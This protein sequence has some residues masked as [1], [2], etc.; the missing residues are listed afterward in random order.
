MNGIVH[1]GSKDRLLGYVRSHSHDPSLRIKQPIRMR[2]LPGRS[3]EYLSSLH[4]L[5]SLTLR[6]IIIEHI[7][8]EGFHT[9]FS[10]FRETLTY[11]SLDAFTA[12][13]FSALVTLVDYFPNITTLEL[14]P[15]KL[16]PDEGPA[17]SLSRPFR[18]KLHVHECP[19]N[20][21]GFFNLFARLDLEYEELAISSN[22]VMGSMF[23][24]SVLEISTSTIKFLKLAGGLGRE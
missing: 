6:S 10:A 24:E 14:E 18:G 1:S 7:S 19:A 11:L 15:F 23:L 12:A 3:G 17:P 22:F 4:N 8:E 13:P 16:R 20:C 9:C 5:C 2:H 21:L